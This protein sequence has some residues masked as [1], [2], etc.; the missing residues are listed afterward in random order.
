[1]VRVPRTDSLMM[2]RTPSAPAGERGGSTLQ[3]D[4]AVYN[5][6]DREL[7]H[8]RHVTWTSTDPARATVD[9][10]GLVTALDTG[11]VVIVVEHKKSADSVRV[12]IVPVPVAS[13]AIAGAV[14]SVSLDDT[15]ALTATALDSVGE[16]LLGRAIEWRSSD[17]SVAQVGAGQVIALAT[18]EATITATSEERSAAV[19]LRVWPQPVATIAVAAE[20]AELPLYRKSSAT[21]TL[22]DRRG[23][24]LTGRPVEWSSSAPA[25]L[26]VAASGAGAALS[27]TDVGAALVIARAE[28]REGSAAVTVTN[29]V[30]ARALWVTRLDYTNVDGPQPGK[31][32]T[33]VQNAA[34]ANFNI[35][36]LQVRVAG[37]AFYDS[38]IE[39]CSPRLCRTL[40][41]VLPEDPLAIALAEAATHGI[42]V[43][44]WLNAY[45]GWISGG[46][47]ACNQ[48]QAATAASHM[49]RRHPE[50][51]MVDRFGVTQPCLTTTEYIWA[52]PGFDSVRTQLARVAADIARNYGPRGLQG[53]HLDRIRFPGNAYSWDTA[54]VNAYRRARN[55]VAPSHFAPEWADFRRSLVNAGVREVADSIRAIDP[56]L[57]LSAA[58]FPGYQPVAGWSAQWG[59]TDLYQDPLAWAKQGSLDV[60]VPMAYPASATSTSWTVKT[61]EC[62]NVDWTCALE[63]QRA[64]IEGQGGRHV[65]V[66]VGAI[67][68]WADM[69]QQIGIGHARGVNGFSVFDYTKVAAI[70]DAWNRLANGPFRYKATIPAMP[71]K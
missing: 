61:P 17:P 24:V 65:Y 4:A 44:A 63:Q 55:G 35:I 58:V 64:R 66:G 5:P 42:E 2:I 13:V 53:I 27:A 6:V 56:A 33:I 28:G 25:I 1:M 37:D 15:L 10:T 9:S 71:W 18:G 32:R 47:F 11:R 41:G 70:P 52:S 16:P 51:V 19:P 8:K 62:A 20:A 68:G 43:H 21:A 67:R 3:L 23:K 34:R 50:Y 14:D 36:Y 46:S 26:A 12:V 22:R 60:A 57:V 48:L 69:E 30:E 40:G 49:L 59:Y 7:P 38:D 45:T 54:T 39:P 31:I 29:P